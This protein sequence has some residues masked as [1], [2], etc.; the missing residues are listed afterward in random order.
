MA[1]SVADGAPD[2]TEILL[3]QHVA[4]GD[5]VGGVAEFEGKV[6]HP[7]AFG[8]QE[9][10]GVVVGSAAHEDEELLYPIGHPEAEDAF[11]ER[12]GSDRVVDDEG[13]V[14]EL[15]GGDACFCGQGEE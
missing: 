1:G 9:V 14:T 8:F 2:N 4:R 15:E 3:A 5:Q 6:V 13:D 11:V 10:D 7:A 12:S